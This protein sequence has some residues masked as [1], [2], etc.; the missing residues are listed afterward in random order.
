MKYR[1][2]IT[3]DVLGPRSGPNA[4]GVGHNDAGTQVRLIDQRDIDAAIEP[5][6]YEIQILDDDGVV[7]YEGRSDDVGEFEQRAFAPLDWAEGDG[8]TT[9]HWRPVGK[10]SWRVL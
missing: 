3:N 5:M 2:L 6:R 10:Q 7:Y 9:M 1:W 4:V 8:C